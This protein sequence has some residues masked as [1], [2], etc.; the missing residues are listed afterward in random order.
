MAT[1]VDHFLDG[2]HRLEG[3]TIAHR[4]RNFFKLLHQLAPA[5]KDNV[6]ALDAIAANL[7]P[8]THLESLFRVDFL[9]YFRRRRELWELLKEGND[10]FVS[11]VVKQTWF[12]KDGFEDVSG[13]QLV[14]EILPCLSF[15]VRMKV[16][17]KMSR[18]AGCE[19]FG[20][21]FDAVVRRYGIY[22]AAQ[23]ITGCG[24]DKIKQVIVDYP[25]Q[26]KSKQLRIMYEKDP[27]LVDFY[28]SCSKNSLNDCCY[29]SLVKFIGGTDHDLFKYLKD[30][31]NL[32]PKLGR[33]ATKKYVAVKR[34]EILKDPYAFEH[35]D[36]KAALRK[37]GT[38]CV[39]IFTNALPLQINNCFNI[40]W[41]FR[42]FDKKYHYSLFVQTFQAHYNIEF[43]DYPSLIDE[44]LLKVIP[45]DAERAALAR[46]KVDAGHHKYLKYL[47]TEQSVPRIK[48]KIDSASRITEKS[49]LTKSLL[50]TCEINKNMDALLEIIKYFSLNYVHEDI[51]FRLKF[52]R[53]IR[54]VVGFQNLTEE[55]WN[56]LS[57][58]LH[59]Q[60]MLLLDFEYFDTRTS[61]HLKFSYM[62]SVFKK[63]QSIDKLFEQYF[64][65]NFAYPEYKEYDK[66]F[67][68]Y[69]LE[70][71]IKR[72]GDTLRLESLNAY[73][74]LILEIDKWNE[75]FKDDQLTFY[76]FPLLLDAF[77]YIIKNRKTVFFPRV[78]TLFR[79]KIFTNEENPHRNEYMQIYWE[80]FKH[81]GNLS[82]FCWFLK[83]DLATAT[84]WFSTIFDILTRRCTNSSC[85][86]I[87][88]EIKKFSHLK[89]DEKSLQMCLIK[90][91][92]DNCTEMKPKLVPALSVLMK[93]DD[94][95]A[96]GDAYKPADRKLDMHDGKQLRLYNLQCAIAKCF[97]NTRTYR[98]V[99]SLLGYCA[100]DYFKYALKSLNS[101]LYRTP[102]N[103]LPQYLNY[104][105]DKAVSVR[106]HAVYMTCELS[107]PANVETMLRV[108]NKH[109]TVESL[110]K[111]M[112]VATIQYF[113]KNPTESLFELVKLNMLFISK[114]DE[115][116]LKSITKLVGKIPQKYQAR[117]VV[118]A[119]ERLE[120]TVE[121]CEKL[122]LLKDKILKRVS[123]EIAGEL[124]LEFCI[125]VI[126]Q[127]FMTK[128]NAKD[129]NTM[130]SFMFKVLT[131]K[132][133][134]EL[135]F[136][137][138][139][140]LVDRCQSKN[141][142][143]KFLHGFYSEI[144]HSGST[145]LKYM[146]PFV[147][148]YDKQISLVDNFPDFIK[149]FF[150]RLKLESPFWTVDDLALKTLIIFEEVV[151]KCGPCVVRLFAQE[152]DSNLIYLKRHWFE[153]E[154]VYYSMLKQR[155]SADVAILLL[156]VVSKKPWHSSSENKALK[157]FLQDV[158]TIEDLGVQ[159]CLRCT[160]KVDHAL[161]TTD[162]P[163]CM[164][165]EDEIEA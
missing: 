24:P 43:A 44:D 83:H 145:N 18:Y 65:R 20:E 21:V 92:D 47:P 4:H 157:K 7:N 80:R 10:V 55:M 154:A 152:M 155:A 103:E 86:R 52:I 16:L 134:K 113:V 165:T 25:V 11:K 75:D 68:K 137:T 139:F 53:N 144:M 37:I 96:L 120:N 153:N 36:M 77:N 121:V 159:V 142:V 164:E 151:S 119:W 40:D 125:R 141:E 70:F 73:Y 8:R 114:A 88:S 64:N 112:F 27:G 109:E 163:S 116:S 115:E 81:F 149:M 101:L 124:P 33:R 146:E 41:L 162:C 85:F 135:I 131:T 117:Y 76:D 1:V 6:G 78:R 161:W 3:D 72:L 100:G 57:V 12:F 62:E 61:A 90:L 140:T 156:E 91:H 147:H 56:M 13:E 30:K 133:E 82:D 123:L 98:V 67:A 28:F 48:E 49:K 23:F 15:S 42:S 150:L 126:Q 94:F 60:P 74:N 130:Y 51:S 136:E 22:L 45:D 89:L 29:Y 38:D 63:N 107:T 2:F 128:N 35:I 5:L 102:E 79:S 26:L 97:G 69:F 19:K 129:L 84:T 71:S 132:D 50:E 14:N 9:I 34:D 110:Q 32:W 143:F 122:S 99:P 127:H 160:D 66:N 58:L 93:P 95:A 87:W 148:Y 108:L 158:K 118:Y 104:L 59:T 46:V 31:Y 39:Q 17:R 54:K 138:I 111:Y 105:S 106:K